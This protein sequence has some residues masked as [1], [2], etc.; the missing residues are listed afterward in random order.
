MVDVIEVGLTEDE[1]K[2]GADFPTLRIYYG[3]Y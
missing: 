2:G 3:I 1:F